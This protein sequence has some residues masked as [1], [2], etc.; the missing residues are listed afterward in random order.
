MQEAEHGKPVNSA[1]MTQVRHMS[2]ARKVK[3]VSSQ[4]IWLARG[5]KDIGPNEG[6]CH[7]SM[8]ISK[9]VDCS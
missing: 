6:N 1:W 5:R 7:S 4:F 2:C 9:G 3:I 8:K